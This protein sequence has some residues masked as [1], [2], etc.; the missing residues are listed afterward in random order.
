[1]QFILVH[2]ILV[3]LVNKLGKHSDNL[4]ELSYG[5]HGKE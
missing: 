2:N 3:E 4:E 1:M 5:F